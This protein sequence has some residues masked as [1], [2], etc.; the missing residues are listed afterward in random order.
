[1]DFDHEIAWLLKEK[2]GGV[3]SKEVEADIE[4]IKQGKPVAYV[5]GFVDFLGTRIDLSQRTF[6]PKE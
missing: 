4:R 3:R 1:M 5:I 2:Y 6:I